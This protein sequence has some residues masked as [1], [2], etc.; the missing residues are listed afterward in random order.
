V[1]L[2]AFLSGGIDS[3]SI[4][5]VMAGH[6]S[7]PVQTFSIGFEEKSY[8]ELP[9]ARLVSERF[10]TDHHVR[11][12][13]P[14]IAD[15]ARHLAGF[16]DEPMSDFS[17]FPTYLVSQTARERVTVVLSGD[18]GDEIFGGYEHYV[19]QRL[20]SALDRSP[21][22]PL[23][24]LL[25]GGQRL[26]PPSRQK[27]G[28]INRIK[29]FGAGLDFPAAD[30][31][32]RWMSFLSPAEKRRLYAPGF[33]RE[34]FAAPLAERPPFDRHFAASRRFAGINRDLYLDLKTYLVD[35]IMVK[36]DRMSMA[37][38]LEARA[39]LLDHKL[40]E[41][42]FSLPPQMKVRGGTT[43]WFFKK[44]VTGLLPAKIIRR[45]KEG[46]SIP[47]KHWL[48]GDLRP[49]LLDTL[50]DRR[51]AA[52]GLFSPPAVR[53]LIEEHLS[54]R[55]DHAHRLWALVS[56]FLWQERFGG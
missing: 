22:R 4:V 25:S 50:G 5:A 56:F 16:F 49:L 10:A 13:R 44:A 52:S 12:L 20:A 24:P 38:S 32:F 35:D 45:R 23:Y 42:A 3:S 14:Q 30:R 18:G 28:W 41:F 37:V 6:A 55:A 21:L 40:V 19:A 27:K 8:S 1:P 29:R 43:K 34:E 48:C 31:H 47:I 33:W 15:L 39:P 11:E 36:V 17:S 54:G 9:Y 51:I 53:T 46:F 7:Q 2:G 26:L